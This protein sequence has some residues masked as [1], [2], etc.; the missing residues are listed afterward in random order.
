MRVLTRYLIG[1]ILTPLALAIGLFS[2][3]LVADRLLDWRQLIFL[4]GAGSGLLIKL[5]LCALP[6]VLTLTIPMAYVL[7]CLLASEIRFQTRPEVLT[8]LFLA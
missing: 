4:A 1:Q 7:A 8:W 5:F 2:L 3:V 6:W